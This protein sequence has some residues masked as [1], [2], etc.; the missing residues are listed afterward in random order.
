MRKCMCCVCK[1]VG[2]LLKALQ[3]AYLDVEIVF[4]LVSILLVPGIS[5]DH[6]KIVH[7]FAG[8]RYACDSTELGTLYYCVNITGC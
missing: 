5:R 1:A 2:S 7:F 3:T 6:V 4:R 8:L